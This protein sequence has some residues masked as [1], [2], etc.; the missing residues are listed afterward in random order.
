MRNYIDYGNRLV[1]LNKKYPIYDENDE[2]AGYTRTNDMAVITCEEMDEEDFEIYFKSMLVTGKYK[3]VSLA[4]DSHDLKH[5]TFIFNK[6]EGEDD[7][8]IR[9]KKVNCEFV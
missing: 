2:L 3:G 8:Y 7:V 1:R 4:L 9:D 6:I 5:C